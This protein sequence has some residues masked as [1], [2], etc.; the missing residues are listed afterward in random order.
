MDDQKKKWIGLAA[1]GTAIA[2]FVTR[3]RRRSVRDDHK[4]AVA[5]DVRS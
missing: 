3:L 2:A 1:L 5:S 4:P